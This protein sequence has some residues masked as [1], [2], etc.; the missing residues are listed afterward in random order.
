MRALVSKLFEKNNYLKQLD[1]FLFFFR[2]LKKNIPNFLRRLH[3]SMTDVQ[4]LHNNLI[5]KNIFR[6]NKLDIILDNPYSP[7]AARELLC[8][9]LKIKNSFRSSEN[10][11]IIARSSFLNSHLRLIIN[12]LNFKKLP[13]FGSFSSFLVNLPKSSVIYLLD[14]GFS[15]FLFKDIAYLKK[16]RMK[17]KDEVVISVKIY[18]DN[19]ANQNTVENFI[20]KNFAKQKFYTER[21]ELYYTDAYI[22]WVLHDTGFFEVIGPFTP[23]ADNLYTRSRLIEEHGRY[24]PISNNA[25][26]PTFKGIAIYRASVKTF[27]NYLE[28]D[29]WERNYMYLQ[30]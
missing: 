16:I 3:L 15:I 12:D 5:Y 6:S 26:H 22:R 23:L 9:L 2:K 17:C 24:T 28:S 4:D 8:I 20:L 10:N 14:P 11:I 21:D 29:R 7:E 25:V 27:V 19:E 18:V 13:I 1:S 30:E